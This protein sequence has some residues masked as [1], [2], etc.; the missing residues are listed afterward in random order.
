MKD[1]ITVCCDGF[2]LSVYKEV[3]EELDLYE[4]QNILS[5]SMGRLIKSLNTKHYREKILPTLTEK[6]KQ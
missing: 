3:A 6:Q 5:E 4:G 2:P 1:K